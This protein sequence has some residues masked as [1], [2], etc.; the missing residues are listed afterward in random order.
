[1]AP[2]L[3]ML[4]LVGGL[5]PLTYLMEIFLAESL[6]LTCVFPVEPLTINAGVFVKFG[7]GGF[8]RVGLI[9]MIV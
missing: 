4:R 3:G 6:W 9:F 2:K 1:M 7:A 8:G 5:F